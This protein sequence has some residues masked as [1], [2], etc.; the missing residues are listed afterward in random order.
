MHQV[1]ESLKGDHFGCYQDTFSKRLLQGHTVKLRT[2][3]G[4]AAC[5]AVC[6]E[7]GFAF[8]GLQY[9]VECF[10]GN[11]QPEEAKELEETR[12]EQERRVGSRIL[13]SSSIDS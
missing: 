3:N 12:W 2:T 9:G 6:T 11:T 13:R 7:Y 5:L 4:P 10:C 8:A 1:D